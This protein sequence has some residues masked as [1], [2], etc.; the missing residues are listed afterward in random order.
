MFLPALKSPWLV[1]AAVFVSAHAQKY[2]DLNSYPL[3]IPSREPFILGLLLVGEFTPNVISSVLTSNGV[4]A[5]SF[6]PWVWGWSCH[7]PIFA[8]LQVVAVGCFESRFGF[9][10]SSL[11]LPCLCSPW[12]HTSSLSSSVW[13]GMA[14]SFR[15]DLRGKLNLGGLAYRITN[16]RKLT[17]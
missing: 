15:R 4:T 6:S 16:C 10:H 5:S 17:A 8:S 9:V 11:P 2:L 7:P 14:L 3:P 1:S 13:P 12:P